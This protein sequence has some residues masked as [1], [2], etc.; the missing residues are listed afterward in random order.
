[1]SD[2][3]QLLAG[4]PLFAEFTSDEL[5]AICACGEERAY[6]KGERLWDAGEPGHELIVVVEGEL[7]VWGV[8]GIVARLGPGN[9]VGEIALLL[10]EPRSA[11]VSATRRTRAIALGRAD[12]DRFVR[13]DP[14]AIFAMTAM[15]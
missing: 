7:A 12:F 8:G 11:R 10:D 1:M 5:A 9:A 14:R 13:S 3:E 15:L 4:V 2:L 6:A